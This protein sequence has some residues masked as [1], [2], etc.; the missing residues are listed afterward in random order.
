MVRPHTYIINI[1]T[2]YENNQLQPLMFDLPL[3]IPAYL[4]PMPTCTKYQ[5]NPS[6]FAICTVLT[7]MCADSADAKAAE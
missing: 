1:L 6:T 3:S 4:S 5:N 7:I 2:Q